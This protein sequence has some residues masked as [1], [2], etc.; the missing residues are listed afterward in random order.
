MNGP[1]C[2]QLP[3]ARQKPKA[4]SIGHFHS[5]WPYLLITLLLRMKK[6]RRPT[7][8][9]KHWILQRNRNVKERASGVS[10]SLGSK[11]SR[12]PEPAP[13][14][15]LSSSTAGCVFDPRLS[16]KKPCIRLWLHNHLV[17]GLWAS[18]ATSLALPLLLC[19]M[20]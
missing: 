5:V 17:V 7:D 1:V 2:I 3:P 15:T 16:W 11:E 18:H 13:K 19:K 10:H 8:L 4:F 14:A 6:L 9:K 12:I 20:M